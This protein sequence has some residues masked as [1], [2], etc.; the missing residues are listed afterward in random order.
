MACMIG[1]F[2]LA[3]L[4]LPELATAESPPHDTRDHRQVIPADSEIEPENCSPDSDQVCRFFKIIVTAARRNDV[5]PALVMAIIQTESRYDPR[6][7][8]PR[9]AQGLMQLMPRTAEALGVMDSFDPEQN[10]DAGVRYFK[11][12]LELFAG[13][14][15]LA[16]AAY[17]AGVYSVHHHGGIPPFPS[18]RAYIRKVSSWYDRYKSSVQLVSV[19]TDGSMNQ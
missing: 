8:S 13:D 6:A 9:G 4:G 7:V 1:F 17:N 5:E 15:D 3:A 2:I 18:T 11:R 19:S 12:L 16:L 14:R 10:V